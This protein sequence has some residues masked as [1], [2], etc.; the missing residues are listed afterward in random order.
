MKTEEVREKHPEPRKA[1]FSYL[2][3][4]D[5]SNVIHGAKRCHEAIAFPALMPTN[6]KGLSSTY[7]SKTIAKLAIL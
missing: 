5:H 1:N 3:G 7:L 2:V 4:N 6:G